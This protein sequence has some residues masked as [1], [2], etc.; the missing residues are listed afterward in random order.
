MSANTD[1]SEKEVH[2]HLF[3]KV[4]KETVKIS[5]WAQ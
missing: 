1:I 2:F 5:L 3:I 4:I